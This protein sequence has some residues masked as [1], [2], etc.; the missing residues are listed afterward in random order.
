MRG[1]LGQRPWRD[2]FVAVV[3]PGVVDR[4]D[5][6]EPERVGDMA[7]HGVGVDEQD[8]LPAPD[9][10]GGGQ[11]HGD[12]GL[13]DAALRVEHGHD[14]RPLGAAA[15]RADALVRLDDRA[16][17]V[18]DGLGSDEHRLDPPAERFG[19]VGP[20][21]V[22]VVQAGLADL[23]GQLLERPRRNDHEGRDVPAV[24]VEE[25]IELDRLVE[26][27]LA[28]EHREGELAARVEERGELLGRGH[29]DD[30]VA[31]QC[32]APARRR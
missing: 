19:R 15:G 12:R 7:G 22:L 23:T 4:D 3:L 2:P 31:R 24:L 18:V 1:Q 32:G 28:V 29:R 27:A 9:L 30:V 8:A 5:L 10:E 20:G 6:V 21:E 25:R 26:V 13:A 11:V 16:F 14:R 17:P